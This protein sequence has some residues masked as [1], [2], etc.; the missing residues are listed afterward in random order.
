[1]MR[2]TLNLKNIFVILFLLLS[3]C[4]QAKIVVP[5]CEPQSSH[6]FPRI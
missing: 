6:L 4:V 2:H 5:L 3:I 1:M